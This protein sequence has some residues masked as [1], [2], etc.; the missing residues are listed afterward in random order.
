MA[1]P[2]PV[3]LLFPPRCIICQK[4]LPLRSVICPECAR[5]LSPT[6]SQARQHGEFY[7][8]CFSPFFYEEPLRSAFLRYKFNGRK[9]YAPIFAK[10][11]ADCLRG[12]EKLPAFDFV[13]WAPLSPLRYWKRGYDQA[14]LLAENVAKQLGLPVQATLKKAYRRPLSQL[15]GE[16]SAR[17]ARILDAYS[18]R[19]R[20]DVKGKSILLID[21]ITTSGAT[22]SECARVLKTAG[23]AQVY[24]LT[25]ARK[26]SDS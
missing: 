22:L 20:A 11:M 9:Q 21:D 4:L 18:I 2:T 10:W 24:C 16:R 14:G 26:H 7:D 17:M 12:Q 23:A 25:L 6:G 19:S 8:A 5:A 1:V 15:S 3:D 13:T